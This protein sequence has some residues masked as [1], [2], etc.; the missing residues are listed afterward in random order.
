MGDS[1]PQ[2]WVTFSLE[3]KKVSVKKV[4]PDL[5]LQIGE[6]LPLRLT[7]PQAS[8]HHAGSGNLTLVLSQGQLHQEV[9]L[10]VMKGEELG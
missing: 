1:S 2:S 4:L 7:L 5:K 9:N 8:H 6:A 3:N 10:V